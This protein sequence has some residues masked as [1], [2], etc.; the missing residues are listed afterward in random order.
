MPIVSVKELTDCSKTMTKL[1][2]SSW[3]CHRA[4]IFYESKFNIC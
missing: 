3:G 1:G 4:V 2:I